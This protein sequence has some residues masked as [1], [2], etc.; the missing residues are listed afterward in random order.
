M[1]NAMQL[2]AKIKNISKETGISAQLVLQN[3]MLERLLERISLSK[4]KKNFI[5]KGGFL[6]AS[7]VGLNT[8]ATMDMDVTLKGL[9]LDEQL[10]L[11]MFE[12]IC[13]IETDDPFEFEITKVNEVREGDVYSGFKVS[14]IG[15]YPPMAVPIKLDVTT[16][17]KI[18][19]KEISFSYDMLFDEGYLEIFAYNVETIL[20]EK[21][22]T[23]ISRSDQN[24]RPRDFYDVYILSKL[25]WKHIDFK[26]LSKALEMTS[27]HRG[28]NHMLKDYLSIIN[29]IRKSNK[30]N[31]YW[32]KYQKDFDYA[33]GLEFEEVLDA[34]LRVLREII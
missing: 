28:S 23:I 19:P 25:K 20:A 22:E 1:K 33:I 11:D 12:K 21:L 3:Y 7:I 34:V 24:T 30:M 6:I 16:G 18:T 10:L 5:L 27:S 14:L 17:D 13:E 32:S 15:K 8:R 9:P 26:V 4:Y 31:D 2:K 29:V